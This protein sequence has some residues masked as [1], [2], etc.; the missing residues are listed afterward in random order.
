M[1]TKTKSYY[2]SPVIFENAKNK[3][4]INNKTKINNLSQSCSNK[5]TELYV[6]SGNEN[7]LFLSQ[8]NQITEVARLQKL[9]KS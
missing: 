5:E 9:K 4:C 6:F 2:T 7:N 8:K 3:I 1:S